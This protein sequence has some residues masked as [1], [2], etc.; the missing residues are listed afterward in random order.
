MHKRQF[1]ACPEPLRKKR[2]AKAQEPLC[3]V[4]WSLAALWSPSL[5]PGS[6]AALPTSQRTHLRPR[7]EPGHPLPA[8]LG[9]WAIADPPGRD[10]DLWAP[11]SACLGSRG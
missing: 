3:A 10:G 7:E 8:Q 9:T 5:N 2:K 11:V 4:L 1:S 6:A